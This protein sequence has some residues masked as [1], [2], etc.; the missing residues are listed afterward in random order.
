MTRR[1]H[2]PYTHRHKFGVVILSLLVLG[3]VG[4]LLVLL[5]IATKGLG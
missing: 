2:A 5:S 3:L 1:E 4:A